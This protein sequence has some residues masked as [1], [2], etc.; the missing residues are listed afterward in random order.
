MYQEDLTSE[1]Q[2]HNW[3]YRTCVPLV[4][5]ITFENGEVGMGDMPFSLSL[6]I[7]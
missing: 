4:R 3:C 7:C 1:K 6:V 2:L 5:E